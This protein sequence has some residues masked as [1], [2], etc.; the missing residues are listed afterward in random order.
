MIDWR[1]SPSRSRSSL[2]PAIVVLSPSQLRYRN[3]DLLGPKSLFKSSVVP[4]GEIGIA[5]PGADATISTRANHR[6]KPPADFYLIA[7][8][9]RRNRRRAYFSGKCRATVAHHA[10]RSPS[11]RNKTSSLIGKNLRKRHSGSQCNRRSRTAPALKPVVLDSPQ[12]TLDI[13]R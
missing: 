8:N 3:P 2:N 1:R 13:R 4:V 6:T 5:L 7:L 10:Q 11:I 9:S 12:R